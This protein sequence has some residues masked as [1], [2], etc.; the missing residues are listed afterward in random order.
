VADTVGAGTEGENAT[1]PQD[2]LD[3]VEA[4]AKAEGGGTPPAD[5]NSQSNMWSRAMSSM[6]G[7]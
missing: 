3:S 2:D 1:V 6:F 4:A 5:E 7:R